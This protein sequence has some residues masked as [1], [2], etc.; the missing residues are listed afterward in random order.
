MRLNNLWV[1]L[2]SCEA[3]ECEVVLAVFKRC[4]VG[5]RIIMLD[6]T[7]PTPHLHLLRSL[8]MS[9][10]IP[11][12]PPMLSRLTREQR[13]FFVPQS[14][15]AVLRAV[16]WTFP[17]CCI[18]NGLGVGWFRVVC[19][20]WKCRTYKIMYL[21]RSDKYHPAQRGVNVITPLFSVAPYLPWNTSVAF[22]LSFFLAADPSWRYKKKKTDRSSD[23]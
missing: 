1:Q 13:H 16:C 6:C 3:L 8:G 18:G 7:C 21:W 9:G 10:S 17:T 19:C 2:V 11:L 23:M 20:K 22:S 15:H 14:L 5:R 4:S 12:S